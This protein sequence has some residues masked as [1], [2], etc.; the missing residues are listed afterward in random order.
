MTLLASGTH[1]PLPHFGDG[2]GGVTKVDFDG[3]VNSNEGLPE[4]MLGYVK[5]FRSGA[6]ESV[7]VLRPIE[8]GSGCYFF[9]PEFTNNLMAAVT[10]YLAL[11]K[12][13]DAGLPVCIMLSL[14]GGEY[15]MRYNTMG[16]LD[17]RK[18][19][20]NNPT[21]TL[22]LVYAESYGADVPE[23]MRPT[24]NIL[25]NAFGFAGCDMYVNGKYIGVIE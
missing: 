15:Y 4:H 9:G 14:V 23:L 17:Y 11:L 18:M 1:V 19:Q 20:R 6:L 21:I 16:I 13:Y 25:W 2:Q 5:M 22:P 8:K 3:F 10:R 7:G 24:L 12:S